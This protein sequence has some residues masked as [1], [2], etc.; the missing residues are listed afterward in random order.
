MIAFRLIWIISKTFHPSKM[1]VPYS[2]RGSIMNRFNLMTYTAALALALC[3]CVSTSKSGAAGTARQHM[4]VISTPA[5]G[6]L[7]KS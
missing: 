4:S 1:I 6:N 3:A 5:I 7:V 2:T